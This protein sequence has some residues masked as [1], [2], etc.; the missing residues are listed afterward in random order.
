M[1]LSPNMQAE[2]YKEFQESVKNL[3]DSGVFV[4]YNDDENPNAKLRFA[5][6]DR[7]PQGNPNDVGSYKVSDAFT[8]GMAH[9]IQKYK[10]NVL[11]V[12]A[13]HRTT[14]GPT[15]END[16]VNY[17]NGGVSWQVPYIVGTYSLAKQANPQLKPDEFRQTLM[18]TGTPY[19]ATSGELVGKIINPEKLIEEV[20]KK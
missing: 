14:A 9:V 13:G 8:G 5:G 16:Y 20:S 15:G 12:P 6:L 18:E 1:S 2:D 17:A 19:Y 10:G 11:L 4:Q 7:D 3:E